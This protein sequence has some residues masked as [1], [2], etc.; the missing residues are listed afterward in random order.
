MQH[1]E[2]G[3][4]FMLD[5]LAKNLDP[6]NYKDLIAALAKEFD[7]LEPPSATANGNGKLGSSTGALNNHSSGSREQNDD[8]V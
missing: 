8:Y 7:S 2:I 5:L 6:L 3:D 1:C 4:W